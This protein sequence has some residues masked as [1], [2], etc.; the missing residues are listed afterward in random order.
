MQFIVKQTFYYFLVADDREEAEQL[1]DELDLEEVW[2]LDLA[3]EPEMVLL[4]PY[5]ANDNV[6]FV[7]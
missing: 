7:P 3:Q 5:A 2:Q 6:D 1:F 4:D